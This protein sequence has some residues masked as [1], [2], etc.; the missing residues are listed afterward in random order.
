MTNLAI[1]A[2]GLRKS[3]G[4]KLVL[5]GIDLAVPAG[6][7]FSLLGPNGAGKTTAVKILSTLLGADPGTGAIHVNGHDLAADPQAVRASIGVTGQFSAVDGLITGEENML[8][9]ADLHHLSRREGRRVAGELLER[10]DLVEAAK[11]PAASYSGGMKRR[12]DI[13]MT[14]VGDPR[15]IFLDEP[16]TGLDPRS[17]HNM[18][19]IIRELVTGGVTVFLTTQYLE[20]ADQ[21]ADRIAVLNDGR[22]AAEGT[23][24]E[25]KRLIPGGH[26]RLRF[27]DP[28]AYRSAALALHEVTRD[29][30]ALA[31]QIPSDGSQRELRAVLDRLEAAGIEAD[32]LTVHTPDLDDVF[33]ALTGPSTTVTDQPK[34]NVR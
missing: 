18:W 9:M 7:V 26:V 29:D 19:Q 27:T 16:T 28:A 11:K 2:N 10:F 6:T 1:A 34:E 12:L 17:R 25:L 22:I 13:A 14:L 23:A 5:D 4:D 30:E 8:L 20:E 3:Y 33:F 24:D 15:V 31:L 21:L 32:E